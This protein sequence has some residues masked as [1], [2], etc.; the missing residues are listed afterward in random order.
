VAVCLICGD[1]VSVFKVSDLKHHFTSKHARY[2]ANLSLDATAR[3]AKE[4]ALNVKTQQE[5]LHTRA[6]CRKQQLN[7]DFSGI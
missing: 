3:K 5:F 6:K 2:F 1:T 4:L 7:Q